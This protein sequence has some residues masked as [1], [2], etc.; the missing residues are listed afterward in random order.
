MRRKTTE[1]ATERLGRLRWIAVHHKSAGAWTLAVTAVV[2]GYGA[3]WAGG[4]DSAALLLT[5]A[6]VVAVPIAILTR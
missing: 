6:Y 2:G 5:F 3:L 1:A 4:V